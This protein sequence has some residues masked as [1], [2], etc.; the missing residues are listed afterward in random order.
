MDTKALVKKLREVFSEAFKD[1]RRYSHIWLSPLDYDGLYQSEDFVLKLRSE[2]KIER[3]LTEI[4]EV[5]NVLRKN[6][7]EELKHIVS[8]VVYGPN[9]KAECEADDY[10]VYEEAAACS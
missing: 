5:S 7:K 4:T 9:E 1:G 6:F 2:N 8:V 10:L 3:Y